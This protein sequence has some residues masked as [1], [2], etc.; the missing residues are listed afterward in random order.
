MG[1]LSFVQIDHLGENTKPPFGG[2]SSSA[3]HTRLNISVMANFHGE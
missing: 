1:I 2:I 3:K